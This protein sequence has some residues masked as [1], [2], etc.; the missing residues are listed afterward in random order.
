MRTF[1]SLSLGAALT[2]V[3]AVGC[4][5]A[6][7]PSLASSGVGGSGGY[8]TGANASSTSTGEPSPITGVGVGAGAG[9]AGGSGPVC[10]PAGPFDGDELVA[11]PKQW[12]WVD[13]PGAKCRDGSPTGIG[14]RL[15]PA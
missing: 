14:V 8:F 9:G 1:I 4:G 5:G 7:E 6:D 15:N 3:A 12:T 13:I 2:L 11:Q 10:P